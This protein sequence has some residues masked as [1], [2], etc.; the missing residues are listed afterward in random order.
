MSGANKTQYAR[1][2]DFH[3]RNPDVLNS[4]ANLSSD[5]V[6]TPPEFANRMLDTLEKSWADSN[7]GEV[8][9]QNSSVTF[10]DPFTKS[11]VFLR[12]IASRLIKGLESEIPDLQDRVDHILT[13]QIF[14]IATTKLTSLMARRSV[15]CSK[16]ANGKHS[17]TKKFKTEEGNI[18]FEPMDHTWVGGKTK[19]LTMDAEGNEIEKLVDAKCKY[20]NA[21][22]QELDR[23]EGLERHAYGL[24]HNDDPRPWVQEVFGNEMKFDVIVGNPPYQL[25]DK[26]FSASAAPIYDKFVTQALKL[27][28][29]FLTMVTPSRWFSGG[30]GLDSFRTQMLAD[31]RIRFLVDFLVDKDAFPSV[32]VN[33]G[34]SYFLWDAAHDG[35]CE[36]TTVLP[37]GKDFEIS[38]RNL[39]EFDVFV[40][41][42][43][44]LPLVRDL[45][46]KY[47]E[48]FSQR[49]FSRKPFGLPSNFQGSGSKSSA[50]GIRVIGSKR[51]TWVSLN[52]ISNN[53]D[54][55]N[56]WKVMVPRASDGNEKF[57]LPIWDKVGAFV[58]EPGEVCTETYLVAARAKSRLEAQN[59]ATYLNTK[60]VKFLVSLR[61]PTQDNKADTFSFVPL[62]D[63]SL[64]WS[65]QRLVGE[66]GISSQTQAFIDEIIR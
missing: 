5:E 34:I 65:D 18:W 44:A 39:G 6:F 56:Q 17:V 54:L 42:E 1:F 59:I 38:S 26:G 47:S 11:G 49:V 51:E 60:T 12:E 31:R 66:F 20:C 23:A 52:E 33:G 45:K 2:V 48:W 4:I 15:Y 41:W 13:E 32:N 24:I 27:E 57:P 46:S 8:I 35:N 37:G 58:S 21:S 55:A 28:P 50:H 19:V 63:F 10:L 61:K 29:R 36:V 40:R 53:R 25:E 43:R 30:K 64:P 14:G 7:N 3:G 22:R 9:W 16:L 62:V